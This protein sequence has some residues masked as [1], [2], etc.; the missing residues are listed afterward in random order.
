MKVKISEMLADA[1]KYIGTP[2]SKTYRNNAWPM[3]AMDCSSYTAAI[4]SLAGFPL[5]DKGGNELRTSCYEVNAAGFDLIW[6]S[7]RAKIG[8]E[9]PSPAGLLSSYDAKPG[10]IVF[11]C[12]DKDTTRANKITHVGSILN[13]TT[14]IHTAN[15]RENCCTKPITYGDGYVCAI[16]R[17][18][19]DAELP[20]LPDLAKGAKGWA[21]RMLQTALNLRYGYKLECSG[22]FGTGTEQAVATVN[23]Q[24]N[25]YGKICTAATWAALGF[26]NNTEDAKEEPKVPKIVTKSNTGSNE[27][28]KLQEM[29]NAYG[30]TSADGKPLVED[31]EAGTKT[32]EAFDAFREAHGFEKTVEVPFPD[33]LKLTLTLGEKQYGLDIKEIK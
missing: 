23:A 21:V 12:F 9:L 26:T 3:G 13:S 28:L 11:W 30:Y 31:G 24:I 16:I 18:R 29:L 22:S 33:V 14:I 1:Q 2:Y 32:M 7:S 8:K 10:D 17:L 4:W 19:D 6:P 20:V 25:A 5:L 15:V 27:S